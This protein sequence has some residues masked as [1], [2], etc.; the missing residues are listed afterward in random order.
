MSAFVFLRL[1][2]EI[3]LIKRESE[4]M[5]Q[6]KE[7]LLRKNVRLLQ[8]LSVCKNIFNKK[9][10]AAAFTCLVFS[11]NAQVK[12]ETEIKIT[13]R[14]LH[15]DG[16]KLNHRTLNKANN[17]ADAYDY[18]FGRNISAHGD[19]VKVYKDYVFMTWYRGGKTDRHVMLS[20]YNKNTGT[21]ATIEFPH[22]HTGFRGDPNIG[23]SHNT[24]GLAIS[25]MNGT[26]HMV[27]DLHA[28]DNNNHGGK[29][30][31]DF[32]RYS[33]SVANTADVPDSDFTIDKFVKDTSDISQGPNDYK[34]LTMTGNLNDA[35]NFARLTY[36]KFFTNTDGTILLYMRLGG[37]NNGAYVF[38]RYD[39][40]NEKWTTFTKFNHNNQQSIGNDYN[41]G[42]Y[43]N[44]KYVNGKLRVGFQ[45][46]S[47]DN[48]DKYLYQNGIY[49]AYSDDP[50][51]VGLWKNHLGENMTWPLV[52]S[53]EIKIMEPGDYITHKEPNSVHIVGNFDWTVTAKGDVHFISK[54]RSRDM[55]RS[56][57]QEVYL[58][59]YKPSDSKKF[60][61]T[62]DFAGAS[63]IYTSGNN[64]YIIG[65]KNGF[66]YIE[67]A[68]GGTNEFERVYEQTSG[69]QFDHGVVHVLDGKVYYYLME[70]KSGSSMPLH[71]QIIDLGIKK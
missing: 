6:K 10:L 30:K 45:Q 43:G 15:F 70:K 27:Y 1:L 31:D 23:E 5:L 52:D 47:G 62:S 67:K 18:F 40:E 12:L 16:K 46:R 21:I 63:K 42:L 65:L 8:I 37:N 68:V 71:L 17:S 3:I 38:N 48:S 9:S 26:I 25:P 32:F 24:I 53:D 19:S 14:G 51:G 29:F 13:D 4:L 36:P 35:D 2:R 64:I 49:Y 55:K 58:H 69:T 44:M 56:D 41:W 61:T 50:N 7:M 28:Y 34:H 22:R 33:F 11:A 59:T 57:F 66:P 39:H 20:R 54:V 60:I